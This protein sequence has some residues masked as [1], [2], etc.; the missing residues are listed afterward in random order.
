MARDGTIS[1]IA[2]RGITGWCY[3]LS[4]AES[5]N[6]QFLIHRNGVDWFHWDPTKWLILACKAVGLASDLERTSYNEVVK[7]RVLTAEKQT[8][9]VRKQLDWGPKK[10]ELSPMSWR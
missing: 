6:S 8:E 1:I 4:I 10:E 9:E 2:F 3:S 7:A 5:P